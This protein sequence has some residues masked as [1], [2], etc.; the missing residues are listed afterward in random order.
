M[1]KDGTTRAGRAASAATTSSFGVGGGRRFHLLD[2]PTD[3][4]SVWLG[5]WPRWVFERVGMFDPELAQDQ[6]EEL[7]Q[8][9]V[10]A[11][12]RVRFDPTIS[13]QYE[14]RATW[15]GLFRQY[16]LLRAVEGQ[17]HPEAPEDPS[18]PPL[19]AGGA[20]RRPCSRP[21]RGPGHPLGCAG[22]RGHDR[23]LGLPSP[24]GL[25]D[26][27]PRRSARQ[28]RTWSL[29]MPVFTWATAL[30]CGSASSGSLRAGSSTAGGRSRSSSQ[31]GPTPSAQRDPRRLTPE[32]QDPASMPDP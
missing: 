16:F 12:G 9:I 18:T 28:S 15:F 14:S 8:R 32:H 22:R 30:A 21:P 6:D 17:G 11:G 13:A 2:V 5:C 4:D 29:P 10:D 24:S 7:N 31:M 26:P 1:R 19:D 3:T 27:S 20:H 25:H 23:S